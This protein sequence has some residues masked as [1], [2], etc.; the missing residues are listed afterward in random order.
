MNIKKIA[1]GCDHAGYE[2]KEILKAYLQTQNYEIIDFGTH[3]TDSVDYADYAHPLAVSVESGNCDIGVT[4]CGSGNGINMTANK[5]KG[6]RS[7]LCWMPEISRLARLH[8]DAN[9]CSLPGRF[10]TVEDAKKI[11]DLFLSTE[12]EGGRH[13][14]R[15][16]K[17]CDF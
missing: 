17:M 12:F 13:T 5:H 4:I 3:S 14:E 11:V 7:A 15:I 1:I 16:R 8:N 10:I 2:L 9:V 6:I